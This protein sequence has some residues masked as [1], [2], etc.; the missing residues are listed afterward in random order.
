MGV[1]IK[2]LPL[3]IGVFG[4]EPWTENMRERIEAGSG[5]KAYDIYGLSEI[6]GPGVAMECTHQAGPHIFE[7]HV[8]PGNHRSEDRSNRCRTARKANWC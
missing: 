7:D 8:L 6:V 2:E 5:I 3:R 1:N 4:A